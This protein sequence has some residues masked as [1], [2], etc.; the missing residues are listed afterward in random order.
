MDRLKKTWRT[1][2]DDLKLNNVNIE[3]AWDLAQ[4]KPIWRQLTAQCTK[5]RKK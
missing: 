5:I 1:F 4:N 3:D 2:N